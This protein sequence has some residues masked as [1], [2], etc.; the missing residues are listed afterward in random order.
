MKT[1][2]YTTKKLNKPKQDNRKFY[3]LQNNYTKINVK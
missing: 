2:I 1:K 3:T